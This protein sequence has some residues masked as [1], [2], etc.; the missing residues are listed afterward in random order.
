MKFQSEVSRHQRVNHTGLYLTLVGISHTLKY[1]C[2]SAQ[3]SPRSPTFLSVQLRLVS[4]KAPSL[5][6]ECDVQFLS[7]SCKVCFAFHI[8]ELVCRP[9]FTALLSGTA[10]CHLTGQQTLLF[11]PLPPKPTWPIEKLANK[12]NV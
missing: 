11:P 6:S 8:C 12:I 3:L 1:C 2:L 7:D 5:S 10:N 4:A 9:P